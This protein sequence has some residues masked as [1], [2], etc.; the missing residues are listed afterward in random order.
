M[1]KDKNLEYIQKLRSGGVNNKAMNYI[2]NLRPVKPSA[3]SG[4]TPDYLCFTATGESTIGLTNNR[5]NAPVLFYSTDKK[6]WVSWDY[7][8]ITL[9]DGESVY[10][11]GENPDGFSKSSSVYS[12]FSMN[13]SI[14]ASGNIQTLLSKEGDRID[15]PKYCF[16]GLFQLCMSLTTAPELPATTLATG[17]YRNMFSNCTSLTV[18]PELPATTLALEC[19]Y[20]MFNYCSSFTVA[21][22]LPATVLAESCYQGMFANC[23]AL[24]EAPAL[25]ATSLRRLCYQSMFYGCTSLTTAPE[26]PAT[27]VSANCY[28]DMFNGC[29]S[30]TT[31]PVLLATYMN[32]GSLAYNRMFQNCTNLQSVTTYITNWDTANTIDWLNGAGTSATNPTVYCPA[33]STIPSDNPSG[34]PT[35]WTRADLQ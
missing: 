30:L 29:T 11:Y 19:Y 31:A 24:T 8:T 15:V 5:D 7:S 12:S 9:N 17:C 28:Y 35:G 25:P 4:E 1:R 27:T 6:N 34:I 3:P 18:A 21:P 10:F 2:N 16:Y 13:G 14:A 32:Y 22:K 20:H 23:T 26:L 33:D